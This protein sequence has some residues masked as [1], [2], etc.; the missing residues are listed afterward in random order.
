MRVVSRLVSTPARRE[1]AGAVAIHL[2]LAV[3]GFTLLLLIN[4]HVG[5]GVE[6]LLYRWDSGNYLRVA[7]RGYP[8]FIP[9]RPDGTPDY[10]RLA[11]FPLVPA[12]IRGLHLLTGLSY[13]Y[14][15]VAISW[16]A[17]AVAA[18]GVYRLMRAAGASPG[19]GYACVALWSCSPYAFALWVPYSE[20]VFSAL[21]VWAMVALLARRWLTVGLLCLLAGAVRPTAVVLIATVML[22]AGWALVHRRDGWRPGAAL[23]LA[24]LGLL[25]GWLFLG[26]RV[27]RWDGWFEAERAWGQ[28][29]DFGTGTVRFIGDVLTYRERWNAADVRHAAVLAVVLL[30]AVGVLALAL[31]RTVPRLLVVLVAGAWLLMTGTPGSHYSKPRFMLPFLP[32]LLLLVARP[33][34][35]APLVVQICLYG[36]GAVVSGW[37][38]AGLLALFEG[39]P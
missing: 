24:P 10:S 29:F 34:A 26:S 1:T 39:S 11:F 4:R 17:A 15:G 13:A 9:Y 6:W 27:G 32:V 14:A 38:A 8:S 23:A 18:A 25:A 22:A 3:I 33:L 7:E 12:L 2:A 16:C 21:L 37:Y 30:T 5:H 36:G 28:S 31:D 35:R 20:A 19:A